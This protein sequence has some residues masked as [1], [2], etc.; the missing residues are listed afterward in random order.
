MSTVQLFLSCAGY[1]VSLFLIA[2]SVFLWWI[3]PLKISDDV[4]GPKR[5]RKLFG[6]SVMSFSQS[7]NAQF[8]DGGWDQWPTIGLNMAR[9]CCFQTWG[10]PTPNIGFGGAFFSVVSPSCLEHILKT[11]A[12]NY[13]KGKL[14]KSF[15]ELMGKAVFTTDGEEWKFHRKIVTSI[16]G[17]DT[18]MYGAKLLQSKLLQVEAHLLAK[19]GESLDFQNLAQKMIFDVFVQLT[20]GVDL[21][22]IDVNNKVFSSDDDIFEDFTRAFDE[23]LD[24]THARFDD[25]FWEI[26]QRF[27][28][29]ASERKVVQCQRVI[30]R[31]A[32]G[33][34][35]RTRRQNRRE[36]DQEDVL[37]RFIQYA[38]EK[39]GYDPSDQQ[40]R[41]FVMTLVMAGRDTTAA[42]LSW[43]F[44]ELSRHPAYVDLIREEVDLACQDEFSFETT[45]KLPM[46]WAVVMESLRLHPTA[47]ESFRFAQDQDTLP[48][49][50]N[51]PAGALVMFSPYSITHNDC[52]WGEDVDDFNP[53]RW[54]DCTEPSPFSFPVFS[55]GL[56]SCPGRSLAIMELKMAVAFL[57]S[58]FDFLD[59]EGHDGSYHFAIVMKMRNGFPV[60]VRKRKSESRKDRH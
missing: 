33:V 47:P 40:L 42:A 41:D 15:H 5:T 48:D 34:I 21:G 57:A 17:R 49:G 59:H 24:C 55:A 9:R 52:I 8:L 10:A 50:T 14:V 6:Y 12:S 43:I 46:T 13:V 53:S 29:G 25:L 3:W 11:N 58:K 18:V 7:D 23:L 54:S 30:D 4:P 20:F 51:I 44:W 39:G 28:L 36:I 16:M 60:T 35:E 22:L 19:E 56:R 45:K 2:F 31:F 37:S 26:K 1:G 38:R 27:H 32:F